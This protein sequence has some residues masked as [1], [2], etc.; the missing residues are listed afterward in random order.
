MNERTRALEVKIQSSVSHDMIS[1]FRG[2]VGKGKGTRTA[3]QVE[4]W[5]FETPGRQFPTFFVK[6]WK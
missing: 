2:A 1:K 5:W 6:F 4:G 3:K